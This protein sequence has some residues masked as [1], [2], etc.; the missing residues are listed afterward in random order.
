MGR[1]SSGEPASRRVVRG[2]G[3]QGPAIPGTVTAKT[4]SPRR[5]GIRTAWIE[6][7]FTQTNDFWANPI[8]APFGPLR[9]F[10]LANSDHPHHTVQTRALHAHLRRRNAHARRPDVLTANLMGLSGGGTRDL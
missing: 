9:Q 6:L 2:G 10:I 5:S 8:E 3:D 7:C 1:I 4:P